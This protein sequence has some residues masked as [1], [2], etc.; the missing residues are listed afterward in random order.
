[1]PK[2]IQFFV[3]QRDNAPGALVGILDERAQIFG[4]VV[5]ER[6]NLNGYMVDADGNYEVRL[7]T[8]DQEPMI[9]MTIEDC[10]FEIVRRVEM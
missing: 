7:F 6:G 10:G 5:T 4:A 3:R 1:M 9:R 8:T 2:A